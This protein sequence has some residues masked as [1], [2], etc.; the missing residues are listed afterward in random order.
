MIALEGRF[1][2]VVA[3]VH[4]PAVQYV[5]TPDGADI[6]YTVTGSGEPF[7][8]LPGFLNHVQDAW[9]GYYS[10]TP[11]LQELADRFRL[12]NFDSR[13]L[14]L[15]TRC[16]PQDLS[17]DH[18]LSDLDTVLEK[19]DIDRAILLG[20][21]QSTFLAAHY[22]LRNPERV[23]ALILVNG[24]LSWDAWRLSSVYDRLPEEDWELFLYCLVPRSCPPEKAKLLLDVMKQAQ[25]Q[26]D[27]VISA[28]V[29]QSAGIERLAARIRVPSLILH[30][31]EFRLRAVEGPT[32]LARK[33]PNSRLVLMDSDTL[34]GEPGQAMQ[35]IDSFLADVDREACPPASAV[36]DLATSPLTAREVQVLRLLAGGETNREIAARLYL[37]LRTVERHIANIYAKIGARGRADATAYALRNSL[38]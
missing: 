29:W 23:R 22:A 13:G 34:F 35:A 32:E 24:A 16:L 37:S 28:R 7:V 12:V 20:S 6:A 1:M 27:Y 10:S 5:T 18:Y 33:L 30:S 3:P 17:L 4:I 11:L 26:R 14:G 8:F 19:L 36:A 38:T 25:T 9:R 21:C 2:G 31:R 15:S